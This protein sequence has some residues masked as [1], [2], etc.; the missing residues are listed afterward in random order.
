MEI[1]CPGFQCCHRISRTPFVSFSWAKYFLCSRPPQLQ[2]LYSKQCF[3]RCSGR[4]R[5]YDN[6]SFNTSSRRWDVLWPWSGSRWKQLLQSQHVGLCHDWYQHL[7]TTI[8]Q[9][10]ILSAHLDDPLPSSS[11]WK[12]ISFIK[13]PISIPSLQ[14]YRLNLVLN[15]FHI[16]H[17]GI[18][19]AEVFTVF[20][21]Q[22]LNKHNRNGH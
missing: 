19:L 6:I 16:H 8:Y 7:R 13:F 11:H 9:P 14:Y 5:T 21:F 2:P 4:K 20:S 1:S 10:A 15:K 18:Y 22:G 12:Q 3:H 17:W